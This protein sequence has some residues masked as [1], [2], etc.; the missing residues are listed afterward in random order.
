MATRTF[1]LTTTISLFAR[2]GHGSLRV[3]AVDGLAEA[4]VTLTARTESSDTLDRTTVELRGS[5]LQIT[6]PRQ[7]GVFELV[8][9]RAHDAIDF[10]VTVPTGTPLK[11]TTVTAD[12]AV[13]GRCGSADIAA[14][15]SEVNVDHVDGDL[16]LRYGSGNCHI[17]RVSGAVQT[18]SG[19]GAGQFGEVGGALAAA[20][21]SGQLDVDVARGP[22]RF[23][24]GSG[25]ATIAAIYGNADLATGTGEISLGI[26]A[27]VA[28][29]VDLTT[30][31]GV[32]DPQVAISETSTAGGRSIS[33]R[34]RTGT[35]DI[36]VRRAVA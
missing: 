28:A 15:T 6:S 21:G 25:G 33:I 34:A 31:S 36:H 1:P 12:V 23:R 18:R 13:I 2:I 16:R 14:G 35:G 3:T 30:G 5:T 7:G 20:Y 8:G 10:D 24:A 26:P 32:L 17:E 29:Y 22:V 9:G 19:S 27:G 4:V 11:I